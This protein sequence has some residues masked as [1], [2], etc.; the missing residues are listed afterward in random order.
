MPRIRLIDWDSDFFG[1]PIACADLLERSDDPNAL[2]RRIVETGARL[3][4][5]FTR[6]AEE[7]ALASAAGATLV[8]RRTTLELSISADPPLGEMGDANE[9]ATLDDCAQV[10][11][12]ALQSAEFSRFRRDLLMPPDGWVRLYERWADNS[13]QGWMADCVLVERVGEEIVGIVTVGGSDGAGTIGLFAVDEA[14]RG[15]GFGA[16][17]LKRSTHWFAAKGCSTASVV[18]QGDNV[19]ALRLYR[20]AGYQVAN[21]LGVHHLWM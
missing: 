8:D 14:A 3:C 2:R 13:L 19:A 11:K 1:F 18:T 12:L 4:Y 5:V 7:D 16:K 9:C 21:V 10:R 6:D 17:L 20:R 15:Q